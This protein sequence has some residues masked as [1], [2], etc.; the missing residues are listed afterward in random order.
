MSTKQ[1]TKLI[2]E[3]QFIAEVA[4][5][6]IES[7]EGWSPT[8]SLVDA[9]RLDKVRGLLRGG[10]VKKASQFAKV[11]KLMPVGA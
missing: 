6:L 3:G 1:H 8:L 4:V 5:E 7:E 2:H 11:F 10:D 9:E